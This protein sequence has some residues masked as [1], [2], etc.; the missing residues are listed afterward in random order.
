MKIR[1]LKEDDI[2]EV[3][4]FSGKCD[5]LV[6]ERGSIYW[7]FFK[8]FRNTCFV[9]IEENRIVGLIL[10]FVNQNDSSVGFIHALG[11]DVDYRD[12]GIASS[13]IDTFSKKVK[14]KGA[15]SVYLTT[16][17]DNEKAINFYKKRG[18]EKQE[19]FYKVGEKRL[20]LI[21]KI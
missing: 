20:G 1:K 17:P 13:L 10:G 3:T 14:E 11:V 21:K 7:M 12:K 8:F 5:K 19:E 16:L 2:V 6:V 4:A 18:F 9:A 15:E